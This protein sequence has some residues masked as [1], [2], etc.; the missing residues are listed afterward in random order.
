MIVQSAVGM[1]QRGPFSRYGELS[2]SLRCRA[3]NVRKQSGV[4]QACLLAAKTAASNCLTVPG[5]IHLNEMPRSKK[6]PGANLKNKGKEAA[7]QRGIAS[8]RVSQRC[9]L[10]LTCVQARREKQRTLNQ[11]LLARSEVSPP[12]L[13][14]INVLVCVCLPG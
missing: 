8:G 3:P 7:K 10:Q 11:M 1:G 9:S 4:Q 5:S 14:I 2:S 13:T 12:S 6:K